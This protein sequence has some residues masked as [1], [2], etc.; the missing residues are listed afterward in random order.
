MS[1]E[2]LHPLRP[3]IIALSVAILLLSAVGV[4]AGLPDY[5]SSPVD[6]AH[7]QGEGRV[8]LDHKVYL[9]AVMKALDTTPPVVVSVGGA[10]LSY[11]VDG[12]T[13]QRTI[14][15][16]DLGA[17]YSFD[18]TGDEGDIPYG[19]TSTLTITGIQTNVDVTDILVEDQQGIEAQVT[20]ACDPGENP[21]DISVSL[22]PTYQ[23][24]S[25]IDDPVP[26]SL[27][28]SLVAYGGRTQLGSV[29][30][31]V[32]R[33]LRIEEAVSH[34]DWDQVIANRE[35]LALQFN[36]GPVGYQITHRADPYNPEYPL[37]FPHDGDGFSLATTERIENPTI[38]TP[39]DVLSPYKA[40][41]LN[42]AEPAEPGGGNIMW[43][44][45]LYLGKDIS[46]SKIYFE[47]VHNNTVF[48]EE[49]QLIE[50]GE[51]IGEVDTLYPQVGISEIGLHFALNNSPKGW[52]LKW[53]DYPY[54][55]DPKPTFLKLFMDQFVFQ[56]EQPAFITYEVP[57]QQKLTEQIP[58][59]DRSLK[60]KTALHERIFLELE[61]AGYSINEIDEYHGFVVSPEEQIVPYSYFDYRALYLNP[62]IVVSVGGA[63]LSYEIDGQT[64]Q[65][66]VVVQ[67]LGG[68]YSFD[69]TGD[70][71]D[72]PYGITF[73]LTITDIQTNVD[74]TDILVEDQQG[75][76]AQ[77]TDACDPG[78]N[79]CDITLSLNPAYQPESPIDD[80]V[81]YSLDLV[82]ETP[83]GEIVAGVLGAV[84]RPF[85]IEEAVS[86]LDWDQVIANN[87]ELAAQHPS[88]PLF[89]VEYKIVHR[90]EPYNP[91]YPREYPHNGDSIIPVN[92]YAAVVEEPSPVIPFDVF[93][94]YKA[95][96]AKVFDDRTPEQQDGTVNLTTILYVGKNLPAQ[97]V[98]CQSV[99]NNLVL[100]EEGQ[101]VE[102]GQRIG[103][104]DILYRPGGASQ[105]VAQ[106]AFN[107]TQRIWED[108]WEHWLYYIDAKPTFLKLFIDEFV[109]QRGQPAFIPYGGP[110]Y[111]KLAE[112][113]PPEDVFAKTKTALHERIFLEL[114]KAGYSIV[115]FDNTRG[116]LV[117]PEGPE[118]PFGYYNFQVLL[119]YPDTDIPD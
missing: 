16:Q 50:P 30:G 66:A 86:P 9:P 33:A 88:W 67:D 42:I 28:V 91:E 83:S 27:N 6:T 101:L 31:A 61:R 22:N 102:A 63:S 85:R 97:T 84:F 112:Q 100:V 29:G 35:E 46:A 32:F 93:S 60:I 57:D 76:E 108:K 96:I 115:E 12:Q 89:P 40:I 36:L 55:I 118:V 8:D 47:S 95:T 56:R 70:E 15:V 110:D 98:Y 79:P 58:P 11:D 4:I 18:A 111:Q 92:I 113:I 39:F 1:R 71:G 10:S 104:L 2:N 65:R 25:P 99:H 73:T 81:P 51:K 62:P 44:I 77:V 52:D 75:I 5:A 13:I 24:Q 119:F 53:E 87:E 45:A 26:Y 19:I 17:T 20:D 43:A 38:I 106:F 74:L 103:Q 72:I 82:F 109:I 107:H 94:P 14:V 3:R 117:S 69:A 78:E 116:K 80:S 54:F 21:C 34:V 114:E 59:E 90:S 37:E 64:I 68:T 7:A 49:G 48:V 41:V 105:L 23:P